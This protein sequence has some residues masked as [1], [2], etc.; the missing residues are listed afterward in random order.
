MRKMGSVPIYYA[1]MI[2]EPVRRSEDPALLR[3]EGRYTDD[4]NEPGQAYAYIVR[5]PHAH[6][7]LKNISVEKAKEMP[8]VLAIYTAADLV[9]YGP[10]KCALDFKQRDGSPMRKPIRK[11]LAQGK[12]RFVGDPV[13]CVVAETY[14]QA[15]DAAE[16][17][18]VDIEPLPAVATASAAAKPG[19]PQLY[20]DVPGNVALDF[21]WGEPD[22]VA[23]AFAKAA[24]TTKLSLRNTRV[25]VAA[26]EPRAGICSYDKATG[27]YTLTVPGQGVWGQKGQLVDI[28]G[29]TPDKVRIR[30]FHVGGSFGMKAPIYPEYVCLA[31][32]ARALGRPV[33]WT[34]ERSGS[35][36][37][38]HHGRDH[39]MTAELALDR[40]G[41][42]LALRI[43]GY[44]N[45]GAYLSTVAPQPPSMNVVRNVCGVYKIPL[46]EVSTKICF[47]N[48][49][50]VSAYRGAGRP[51]ANMY[52]ERLIDEAAREM[53]IDRFE[54]RRRNHVQPSEIPY[55]NAAQMTVDSGDF[56]AV[57]E[58][59]IKAT[60]GFE[61]R[62]KE[63]KARGKLRGLG[64]GSYMEVTAPPNKEMGGI[65]FG[66]DKHIT[67]ITGTLDYGQGHA[68]P[69][70]QI[71]SSK[72]GVPFESIRLLQSDS[73]RLL[74]GAGTGGSRS[75]MMG[76]SAAIEAADLVIKKGKELAAEALEA[77]AADIEFAGGKFVV[78][79]TDRGISLMDLA[80]KNPG[81]LDTMHVTEVI[82]S[83]FPNGCHVCEVE[84][85][86]ETGE[87]EVVRYNSVNDFGVIVNPLM[88][89]GQIH[90]GVVQGMGQCFMENARYDETGQLLTGSFMDYAIPHFT[91]FSAPI[92]WQSH[93][94]PATTNPL[95]A[96]GCGEAGCAGAMTSVMNAVVDALSELGIRHFDMPAS[97]QRVWEIIRNTRRSQRR[98]D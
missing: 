8:G 88:V 48:T 3:G 19:A 25:V 44:G 30:T 4:L 91:D 74:F 76:G 54:L 71:L 59:A 55:K 77:A 95:G 46:L 17:V 94:V 12:V 69:F 70:A 96:K 65:E 15:K 63:S 87:V 20:D 51:E 47:T 68:S 49:S 41:K 18:E 57:F 60:A 73:D 7:L 43:T 67:F 56:G 84:I 58:K 93:P 61:Q 37:S 16:A 66:G 50:P 45:V 36:L 5:S 83:A 97:P 85:D 27:K 2:G 29:V 13:A 39:E 89:E 6:G 11:S 53:G 75:A 81:K 38:D 52:I 10:H 9:A 35:F 24:H 80:V 21:L 64:V 34:D 98:H 92:E 26:M 33:K 72:L 22:K 90:G 79:G 28:L 32:A 86:P 42:F 40:D 78:G 62:K 82:P 14:M 23:E 1:S 31:H